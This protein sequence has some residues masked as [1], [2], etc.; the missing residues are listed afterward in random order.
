MVVCYVARAFFLC[1]NIRRFFTKTSADEGRVFMMPKFLKGAPFV[2]LHVLREA[3]EQ[4]ES[5]SQFQLATLSGYSQRTVNTAIRKLEKE[6]YVT[7]HHVG[8]KLQYEILESAEI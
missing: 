7:I 6:G 1:Y 2:V 5:P 4:G 3:L 8:R